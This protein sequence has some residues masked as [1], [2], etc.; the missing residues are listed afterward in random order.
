M[1]VTACMFAMAFGVAPIPN[2]QK[3]V[4]ITAAS[5]VLAKYVEYNEVCIEEHKYCLCKQHNYHRYASSAK[6]PQLHID[7]SKTKEYGKGSTA[8]CADLFHRDLFVL[9]IHDVTDNSTN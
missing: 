3:P 8:Q 1:P 5:Y 6:L 9:N 7:H 4:V 2:P